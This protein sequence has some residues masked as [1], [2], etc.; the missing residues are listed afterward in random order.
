MW[1]KK[2]DLIFI[3]AYQDFIEMSGLDILIELVRH[4]YMTYIF[5]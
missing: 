1:K 2:S 4:N 3:I 5:P